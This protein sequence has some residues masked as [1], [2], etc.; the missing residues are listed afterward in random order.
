MKANCKEAPQW[1]W[2]I[3]WQVKFILNKCK[4][5]L[6]GLKKKAFLCLRMDFKLTITVQ[7]IHCEIIYSQRCV[8]TVI[9]ENSSSQKKSKFNIEIFRK[10][11]VENIMVTNSVTVVHLH[12]EKVKRKISRM[13]KGWLNLSNKQ[14]VELWVFSLWRRNLKEAMTSLSTDEKRVNRLWV[15]VDWLFYCKDTGHQMQLVGG[16]LKWNQRKYFFIPHIVMSW[17]SLPQAEFMLIRK[18]VGLIAGIIC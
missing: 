9:Y 17:N 18:V 8:L 6:K 5:V 4:V 14:Q 1:Y 15:I 3:K 2:V 10:K 7:E 12:L 16:M 13:S 11:K